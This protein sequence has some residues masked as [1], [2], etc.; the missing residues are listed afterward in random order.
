MRLRSREKR[1]YGLRQMLCLLE[2]QIIGWTTYVLRIAFSF[3]RSCSAHIDL[4]KARQA[5][6]YLT[7][8]SLSH[9][10]HGRSGLGL[11][12]NCVLISEARGIA[13]DQV[14]ENKKMRIA[15]TYRPTGHGQFLEICWP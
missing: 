3:A 15:S 14:D 9:V 5:N 11:S 8:T 13:Y 6:S 1:T 4:Q 12:P 7:L 2:D 10:A